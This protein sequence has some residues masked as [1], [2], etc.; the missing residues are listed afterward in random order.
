[1]Q[2][3]LQFI[4]NQTIHFIPKASTD[5][6]IANLENIKNL[7]FEGHHLIKNHQIYCLNNFSSKEIYSIPI[8]SSNS[9]PS[10]LHYK[11]VSQNSNLEWNTIYMLPLI[12]TKDSRLRLFQYKLLNNVL[13]LNKMLLRFGKI[14]SSLCFFCKMTDE[15]P[16]HLF[17]NCTKTK[18]VW[19]Q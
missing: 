16:V 2:G 12:V 9:K 7:V 19:D 8:E 10:K 5:A 13:Y 14:D 17:Y 18:L 11:N 4:C 1:M 15:T 3:Q 6:L